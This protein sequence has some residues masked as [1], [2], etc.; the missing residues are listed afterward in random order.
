MRT[1]PKNGLNKPNDV[2]VFDIPEAPVTDRKREA[3]LQRL[4]HAKGV[5]HLGSVPSS[6]EGGK[7]IIQRDDLMKCLFGPDE[8]VS[9]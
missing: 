5:R 7:L 8:E 4:K 6:W 9:R 2:I 3:T 1:K